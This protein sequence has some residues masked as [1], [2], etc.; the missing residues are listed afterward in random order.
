MHYLND[1]E[2][3]KLIDFRVVQIVIGGSFTL[4]EGDSVIIW[5]LY[6]DKRMT[7]LGYLQSAGKFLCNHID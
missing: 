6:S 2:T 5:G 1:C 3:E 7:I 4:N